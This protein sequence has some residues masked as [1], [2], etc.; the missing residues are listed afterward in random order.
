MNIQKNCELALIH[1]RVERSMGS[2]ERTKR[3]VNLRSLILELTNWTQRKAI[4][5]NPEAND[6][7]DSSPS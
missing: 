1:D 4:P 3:I 2:G 6:N 7:A 5:I